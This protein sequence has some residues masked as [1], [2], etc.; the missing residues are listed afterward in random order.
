MGN[1][2]DM[3]MVAFVANWCGHCQRLKPEY[4]A[5]ARKLANSGIRFVYVEAPDNQQLSS[6]FKVQGFP[7]VKAFPPGPKSD[8]SAI[9]YNGERETTAI[10]EWAQQMF[11]Q[12]GGKVEVEVPELVNQSVLEKT[13]GANKRCVVVFAED[14]L[15]SSA[16]SRNALLETVKKAAS[17]ARHVPF[18]WVSAN[19]QPD[20]E[21]AYDLRSGFPAVILLREV[22]GEKVG[23][24]H[25]GKVTEDALVQFASAPRS[26]GQAIKGGWPTIRKT[27]PWDGKD[28]PKPAADEKDDFNLDE[29]LNS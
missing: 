25:K 27:A 6:R 3:F 13:C 29:F 7:T 9:D 18:V 2:N 5:A 14:I 20:L 10:V 28:A 12:H 17:K 1:T 22:D 8:S 19:A 24:V 4:E 23:F 15:D 16:K 21:A 11:E 26:L